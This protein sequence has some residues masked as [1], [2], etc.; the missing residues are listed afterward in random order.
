MHSKSL[1]EQELVSFSAI[2]GSHGNTFF[3]FSVV[4]IKSLEED[5]YGKVTQHSTILDNNLA[6]LLSH[7]MADK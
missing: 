4:D 1:H 6:C 5:L 7:K 2:S 3:C